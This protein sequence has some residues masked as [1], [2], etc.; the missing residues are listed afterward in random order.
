[1]LYNFALSLGIF[2]LIYFILLQATRLILK[3]VSGE[4]Y[5][6]IKENLKLP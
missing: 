4:K 6:K 3:K 1:M 2:L 5:K